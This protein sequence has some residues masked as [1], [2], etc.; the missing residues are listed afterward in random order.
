MKDCT[1]PFTDDID[2]FAEELA[3]N[4]D[5]F[6]FAFLEELFVSSLLVLARAS[7]DL[8][9]GEELL[10]QQVKLL[11][12]QINLPKPGGGINRSDESRHW[13]TECRLNILIGLLA[14]A[15]VGLSV[16]VGMAAKSTC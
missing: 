12:G 3:K 1:V 13:K 7:D 15:V 11:R 10:R 4:T 2:K 9:A 14:L 16:L 6:S 5:N 8:T